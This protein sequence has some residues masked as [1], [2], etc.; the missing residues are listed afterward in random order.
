MSVTLGMGRLWKLAIQTNCGKYCSCCCPVMAFRPRRMVSGFSSPVTQRGSKEKAV[1]LEDVHE[2]CSTQ[3]NIIFSPWPGTMICE[4]FCGNADSRAERIRDALTAF[5]E[6]SLHV[7]LTAFTGSNCEEQVDRWQLTNNGIDRQVTDGHV[8]CR[9]NAE[10]A[11]TTNWFDEFQTL[12]ANHPIPGG[13]HWVRLYCG[14]FEGRAVWNFG[15]ITNYGRMRY[16]RL[17]R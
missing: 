3:V 13:T 5:A 16:R 11:S 17:T 12:L 1:H 9:G 14:Q 4:A 10:L 6:N 15:S 2:K 8:F 7:L